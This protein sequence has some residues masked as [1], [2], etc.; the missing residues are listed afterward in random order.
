MNVVFVINLSLH[1]PEAWLTVHDR[2]VGSEPRVLVVDI[3]PALK[4]VI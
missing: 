1:V 3:P 4:A 2:F